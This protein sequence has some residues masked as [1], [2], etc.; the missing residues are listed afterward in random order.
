MLTLNLIKYKEYY[1]VGYI[2]LGIVAKTPTEA[3]A[4]MAMTYSENREEYGFTLKFGR[5]FQWLLPDEQ[6]I[7]CPDGFWDNHRKFRAGNKE[8]QNSAEEYNEMKRKNA[9][10]FG[11]IFSM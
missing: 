10:K 2:P 5:T 6:E 9:K 7:D 1:Q 4:I 3:R 8:W 11:F